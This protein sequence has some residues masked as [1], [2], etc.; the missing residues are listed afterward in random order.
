MA[1]GIDLA[2]QQQTEAS[3][4]IWLYGAVITRIHFV[5]WN[6]DVKVSL[7]SLLKYIILPFNQ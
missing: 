3:Y 4:I 2:P 7:V 5:T 1:V 6:D